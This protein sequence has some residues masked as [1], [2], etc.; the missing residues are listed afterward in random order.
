METKEIRSIAMTIVMNTKSANEIKAQYEVLSAQ[1]GK[2]TARLIVDKARELR[3]KDQAKLDERRNNLLEVIDAKGLEWAMA[4]L[5]KEKDWKALAGR[6]MC[7]CSTAVE[8]VTRWYPHTIL[9]S[10]ENGNTYG[11]PA[12]KVAVLDSEGNEVLN[13]DGTTAKQ[14]TIKGKSNP[15]STLKACL[16]QIAKSAKSAKGGTT[17]HT[18]GE[19][20]P[21]KV[22]T[23]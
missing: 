4:G 21:M 17:V 1:Y 18:E 19:V 10:D 23:K 3:K 8:L 9:V 22:V 14:W 13:A 20:V 2:E 6:A 15:Q 7:K 5:L 12:K 16:R 11:V